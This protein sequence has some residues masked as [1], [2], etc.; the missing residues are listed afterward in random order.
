MI[1]GDEADPSL[2]IMGLFN[3]LRLFL[4]G[5][6]GKVCSVASAHSGR[7]ACAF[8]SEATINKDVASFVKNLNIS[9]Y[10]CESSGGVEWLQEERLRL[11]KCFSDKDFINNILYN[12]ADKAILSKLNS[13][14]P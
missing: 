9:L 3:T 1:G 12:T 5:H 6:S 4:F 2:D 13:E 10:E 11:D 7:F 8:L 14:H